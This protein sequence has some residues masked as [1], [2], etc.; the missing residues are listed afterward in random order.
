[1]DKSTS[2]DK[3]DSDSDYINKTADKSIKNNGIATR[4]KSE[5][6]DD[7]MPISAIN[8]ECTTTTTSLTDTYMSM[9]LRFNLITM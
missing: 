5:R 9:L 2:S 4:K 3:S 7:M 1:V 6:M 8:S